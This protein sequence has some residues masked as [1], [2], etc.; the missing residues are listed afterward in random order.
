MSALREPESRSYVPAWCHLS[1]LD[2]ELNGLEHPADGVAAGT[3]P[4]LSVL[5]C[6]HLDTSTA[7]ATDAFC[8]GI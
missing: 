4:S 6:E 7:E 1:H 5:L 3:L 8:A 2:L